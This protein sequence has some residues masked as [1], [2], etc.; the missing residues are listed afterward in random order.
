MTIDQNTDY[1]D[2][3]ND[4]FIRLGSHNK[5]ESKNFIFYQ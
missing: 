3:Q 2:Q 1:N 4:Y 5:C